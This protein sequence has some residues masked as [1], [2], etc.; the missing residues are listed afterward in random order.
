M[1]DPCPKQ[2]RPDAAAAGRRTPR[3]DA[4]TRSARA[5]VGRPTR[6]SAGHRL[7]ATP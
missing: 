6:S 7:L 1:L 5:R 3:A 2:G 4:R